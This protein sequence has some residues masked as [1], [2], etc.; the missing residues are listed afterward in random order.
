MEARR[1]NGY[2]G[3]TQK[4]RRRRRRR[5]SIPRELMRRSRRG[6]ARVEGKER[7]EGASGVLEA[8]NATFG[9]NRVSI[10]RSCFVLR[11]TLRRHAMRRRATTC[12]PDVSLSD[13]TPWV[14]WNVYR[15][16]C[17]YSHGNKRR[18]MYCPRRTWPNRP[19]QFRILACVSLLRPRTGGRPVLDANACDSFA[20]RGW[21]RMGVCTRARFW[22]RRL[23]VG[24][25]GASMLRGEK[26]DRRE[27]ASWKG[28][29]VSKPKR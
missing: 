2:I 5:G 25:S 29:R 11:R 15:R 3:R 16:A 6:A 17:R 14:W 22:L 19:V 4:R 26:W 24:G 23:I 28:S 20:G 10:K 9:F 13:T 27:E 12:G 1:R 18:C 8:R 21:R 7:T